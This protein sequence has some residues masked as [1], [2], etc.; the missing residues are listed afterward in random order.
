MPKLRMQEVDRKNLE[1][2]AT[3]EKHMILQNLSKNELAHL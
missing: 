3:I 1:L 2:R